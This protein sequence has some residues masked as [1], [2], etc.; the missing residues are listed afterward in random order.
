[1]SFGSAC[2][3]GPVTRCIKWSRW[4]PRWFEIRRSNP[5]P[6]HAIVDCSQ[7]VNFMLPPE[8]YR[9]VI[10]PV[11]KLFRSFLVVLS[12]C[13]LLEL[14]V[15]QTDWKRNIHSYLFRLNRKVKSP[16][17]LK[18]FLHKFNSWREALRNLRSGSPLTWANDTAAHYAAIRVR[19]SKQLD[20]RFAA[21]RHT[22][23]SISRTRPSRRSPYTTTVF[24][25]CYLFIYFRRSTDMTI[26]RHWQITA[27]A[28]QVVDN[29]AQ[30]STYCCP[31][32][33]S[34]KYTQREQ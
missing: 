3:L 26:R 1:M 22:T 2:V 17:L 11:V 12:L 18:R 34:R 25:L 29:K 30:Q 5:K 24:V 28:Q 20:S 21:S 23:A 7:T 31:S 10:P 32:K 4:S 19:V 9:R 15:T 6:K 16:V 14:T 8:K 13:E 27:A 33:L